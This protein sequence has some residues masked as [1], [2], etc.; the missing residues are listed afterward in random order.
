MIRF[1]QGDYA[2][3]IAKQELTPKQIAD[4]F[5]QY[6]IDSIAFLDG[7]GSAQFGRWNGS[8]FE[9]VRDTGRQIPS[10]VAIISTAPVQ[11]PSQDVENEPVQ[12]ETQKD[13]VT[14]M[15]DDT[16]EFEPINESWSDPEKTVGNTLLA[17]LAALLSVKSIITL[18]LT[19]IFGLLVLKGEELPDKFVSIY[20]MCISFFFGYQ[21]KK[22]EGDG[23]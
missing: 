20:T 13:E 5:K 8:T 3:G 18:F 2:L 21:F 22:A 15:K 14:N 11:E 7:G 4:D 12:D 23:K 9:Y 6:A 1:A 17:R 10:A 19:V 16:I